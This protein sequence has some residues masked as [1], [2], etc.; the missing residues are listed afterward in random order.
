MP[1]CKKIMWKKPII[2]VA[3]CILG[4]EDGCVLLSQRPQTKSYG[5]YWEFPGGKIEQGEAPE[6]ALQR[7]LQEELGIEIALVDLSAEGFITY[8]YEE[9]FLVMLIYKCEKFNGVPFGA[10]GQRVEWVAKKNLSQIKLLP[11]NQLFLPKLC[12]T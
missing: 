3:A 12:D 2:W 1:L 11:S 10:E 7:E 4:R 8:P 6:E 5:G 9:F